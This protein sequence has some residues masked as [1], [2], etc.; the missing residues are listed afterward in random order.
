MEKARPTL[1]VELAALE[2]ADGP[3]EVMQ[4]LS[5]DRAG[6]PR[7]GR[8]LLL[9]YSNTSGGSRSA[10]DGRRSTAGTSGERLVEVAGHRGRLSGRGG[11]AVRGG[12]L[13]RCRRMVG[14]GARGR[15]G[16]RRVV[17][18]RLSALA[19]RL[20]VSTLVGS[21]SS[22]ASSHVA[23]W[24]SSRGLSPVGH[25]LGLGALLEL[26]AGR[27]SALVPLLLL[28]WLLA[29]LGRAGVRW[30][31]VTVASYRASC[32]SQRRRDGIRR[33]RLGAL[34]SPAVLRLL[35]LVSRLP[36]S[37]VVLL[38]WVH[39]VQQR[40]IAAVSEFADGRQRLLLGIAARV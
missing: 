17:L 31:R 29:V 40:R 7:L 13:R 11:R 2:Q 21:G 6:R 33:R 35:L 37:L 20:L 8:L 19:E 4:G 39:I 27:S 28:R 26:I 30:R 14:L 32:S 22:S 10:P 36:S 34:L 18:L 12:L 16:S 24:S 3:S 9:L 38:L 5:C 15:S 23:H 1:G 25:R